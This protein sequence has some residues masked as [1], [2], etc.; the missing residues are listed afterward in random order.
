VVAWVQVWRAC[1]PLQMDRKCS[2]NAA[3]LKGRN[4]AFL[5]D[6]WQLCFG[7]DSRLKWYT[8]AR[9]G[10][11]KYKEGTVERRQFRLH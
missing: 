5:C 9:P 4:E 1:A 3:Q 10:E 2:K 8:Q 7:L 6:R 11:K